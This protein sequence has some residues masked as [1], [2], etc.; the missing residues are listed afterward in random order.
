MRFVLS[1]LL[2]GAAL[3]AADGPRRAPGFALA[4]SKGKIHDLY[5]Y[6]GK[7]VIV[8]FLQTSCPHC[9]AFASVLENV[10]KKYGDKVAILA[11]ANPPDNLSTITPY[12]E[13]HHITYPV[14]FDMGQAAYSYVL[15]GRF[16]L[17]QVFLIDANG[18]IHRHFE[19]SVLSKDIFEGDGLFWEIDQLL[20]P[21]TPAGRNASSKKK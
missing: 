5:D 1:L 4:D 2:C 16:D 3:C 20:A 8:E 19:Y 6:R 13:G 21:S 10:Q 7:P 9:A 11:V 18:M 14:V 15:K 12:I 17:P